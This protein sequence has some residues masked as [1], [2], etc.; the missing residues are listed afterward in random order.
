M[1]AAGEGYHQ[2]HIPKMLPKAYLFSAP[3]ARAQY[4]GMAQP[5]LVLVSD[6]PSMLRPVPPFY[7]EAGAGEELVATICCHIES[8]V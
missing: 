6:S 1:P 7:A 2:G 8:I 4:E 3:S 5:T